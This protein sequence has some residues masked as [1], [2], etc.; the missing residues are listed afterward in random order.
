MTSQ[1]FASGSKG[2]IKRHSTSAM[3]STNHKTPAPHMCYILF[4]SALSMLTILHLR[5]LV[6]TAGLP[7][8][9]LKQRRA[10]DGTSFWVS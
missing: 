4:L 3:N 6:F 2:L 8:L 5:V 10:N 7:G 1:K 9:Y